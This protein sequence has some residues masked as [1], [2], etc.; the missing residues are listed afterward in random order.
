MTAVDR[1]RAGD[2][3]RDEART[4]RSTP[5]CCGCGIVNPGGVLC[6]LFFEGA[7]ALGVLLALAELVSWWAVLVLPVAVA[8][9]VKLNDMVAGGV[10]RSRRAR[11]A[12]RHGGRL[13]PADRSRRSAERRV[14]RIAARRRPR[15]GHGGSRRPGARRAADPASGHAVSAEQPARP[16]GREPDRPRAD[17]ERGRDESAARPHGC[18]ARGTGPAP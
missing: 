14:P 2:R 4:G 16:A 10:V 1:R 17:A 9:M 12:S 6:F 13:R 7:V 15:A 5:G 3:R 8:V 18:D 11:A